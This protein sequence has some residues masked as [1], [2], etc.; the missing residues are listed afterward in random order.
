MQYAYISVIFRM[1]AVI[2]DDQ[3]HNSHKY[4]VFYQN[5]IQERDRE[6]NRGEETSAQRDKQRDTE[7]QKEDKDKQ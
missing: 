6:G 4:E 7:R 3:C 2:R 1:Q 5:T